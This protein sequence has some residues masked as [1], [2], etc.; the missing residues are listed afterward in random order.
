MT[1]KPRILLTAFHYP[2][3][4]SGGVPRMTSFEKYLTGR[5]ADLTL[6]TPHPAPSASHAST[7]LT[8]PLPSYYS[9]SSCAPQ[10]RPLH[11]RI[12][13]KWL[14]LPDVFITWAVPAARRAAAL[15]RQ[16]PFDLVISSAPPESMHL[17]G[18]ILKSLRPCRWLADFCDGWTFEPLRPEASLPLRSSL[19]RSLESLVVARADYITAAARPIAADLA[20]RFPAAGRK[21]M[22]LPPAFDEFAS[23][24]RPTDPSRFH[25]V[26]TGRFSSSHHRR[27][28]V[29]FVD[30]LL[31]A[32]KNNPQ[33]SAD[34][35][36]TLM[37]DF[38]AA[39]HSLWRRPQLQNLVT[40]LP[41]VPHPDALDFA[42]S[43]TAL[44]LVTAPGTTSVATRKLFDYLSL[45]RPILALAHNNEACRIIKE[46]H[47]GLCVPPDDPA[48]IA[49]AL[50]DLY[51]LWK[52]HR[53]EDA[54]P[55]DLNHLYLSAPHLDRT[56]GRV[57]DSL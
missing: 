50:L 29:P 2:P 45:R 43:A 33:M 4:V 41:P 44:L 53:L 52:S 18:F 21:V 30:G 37:G 47:S 24:A 49:D 34:F 22:Y 48:S 35:H 9:K 14:L 54:F 1:R 40:Q 16:N 39:E 19:E 32:L 46:T 27:S 15:H 6:L 13:K 51:H 11:R 26:Y 31:L 3:E 5:G 42:A 17:V 7:F 38:T 55:R 8:V 57:L 10:K 23:P 12:A 28:P 25:L 20:R 36:L 56:L